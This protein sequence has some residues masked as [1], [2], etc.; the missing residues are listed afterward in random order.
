ML[1]IIMVTALR[2]NQIPIFD[3][4]DKPVLIV[5]SSAPESTP[6]MLQQLWL[7]YTRKRT[8]QDVF[9]QRVDALQYLFVIALPIQIIFPRL[10]MP[11]NH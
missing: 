1:F 4:I 5:D 7:A 6:F 2:Y 10:L 11:I 9:D 3:G 8:P